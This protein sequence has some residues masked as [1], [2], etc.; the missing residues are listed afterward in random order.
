MERKKNMND[1]HNPPTPDTGAINE[2]VK[3]AVQSHRIKLRVLTT[4]AFVFG[5]VAIAASVPIAS[6][7]LRELPMQNL[8]VA[9]LPNPGA[10]AASRANTGSV[11]DRLTLLERAVRGEAFLTHMASTQAT[12]LAL[13]VAVLGLGTLILLT[14][15]VLNRR[16][17]LKQIN[18]SLV[19]IS[20]QLRELKTKA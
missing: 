4:V 3:S 7:W 13:A 2:Q 12:G 18:D 1:P 8:L 15:V 17:A 10:A 19:Q 14:V 20:N 11:E 5:F 16:I 6:W 9:D